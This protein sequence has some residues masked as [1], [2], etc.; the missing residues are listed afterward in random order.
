MLSG[1]LCGSGIACR[2]GDGLGT[3]IT[4]FLFAGC[5]RNLAGWAPAAA[6]A[7]YFGLEVAGLVF[8]AD[9]SIGVSLCAIGARSSLFSPNRLCMKV[10]MLLEFPV[11]ADVP[12]ATHPAIVIADV[13]TIDVRSARTRDREGSIS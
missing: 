8:T 2:F 7:G 12:L 13:T 1:V 4:V 6:T 11:E 9:G 5:A 10:P 3:R